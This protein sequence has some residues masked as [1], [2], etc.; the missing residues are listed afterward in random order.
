MLTWPLQASRLIHRAQGKA[1][2]E[3]FG[4]YFDFLPGDL[5]LC[6]WLGAESE[7]DSHGIGEQSQGRWGRHPDERITH[8]LSDTEAHF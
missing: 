2:D 6:L 3:A 4:L 1:P 5:S 8:S 7:R